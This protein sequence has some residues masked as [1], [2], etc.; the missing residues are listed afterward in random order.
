MKCPKLD[1][2]PACSLG[3]PEIIGRQIKADTMFHIQCPT[4]AFGRGMA[5]QDDPVAAVTVWNDDVKNYPETVL[6]GEADEDAFD[7]AKETIDSMAPE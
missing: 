1:P 5:R 2:C 3:V 6:T 7:K 4:C